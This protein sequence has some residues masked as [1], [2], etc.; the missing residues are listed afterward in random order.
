MVRPLTTINLVMAS[1]GDGYSCSSGRVMRLAT[2]VISS[3]KYM[4]SPELR[5]K[6]VG[7][8][9]KSIIR[10]RYF[11]LVVAVV[12]FFMEVLSLKITIGPILYYIYCI[13]YIYGTQFT[14]KLFWFL[15][16][17]RVF[18]FLISSECAN[19]YIIGG[20][21]GFNYI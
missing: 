19:H 12:V 21:G 14:V 4:M 11:K 16:K 5:A 8:A 9:F 18:H 2:S 20:G 7:V 3:G 1:Y 10:R 13:M 17:Y 15:C 6:Q